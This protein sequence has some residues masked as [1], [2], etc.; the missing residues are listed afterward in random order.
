MSAD[1]D[2]DV[3]ADADVGPMASGPARAQHRLQEQSG[4]AGLTEPPAPDDAV[5]EEAADV[6]SESWSDEWVTGEWSES[7][8]GAQLAGLSDTERALLAQL[9]EELTAREAEARPKR[10]NGGS[11]SK[12]PGVAEPPGLA[13]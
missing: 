9:Q 12:R 13:G 8:G 5:A 4:Q 2:V 10:D 3:D 11:S 7:P 1:L 6:D